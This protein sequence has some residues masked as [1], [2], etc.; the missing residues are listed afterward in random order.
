MGK[1]N[2][3]TYRVE[4]LVKHIAGDLDRINSLLSLFNISVSSLPTEYRYGNDEKLL[5]P[6]KKHLMKIA[7]YVGTIKTQFPKNKNKDRDILYYGTREEKA[8]KTKEAINLIEDHYSEIQPSSRNW[9]IFEGYTHPDLFIE[10]DDY[11]LIGEGKWTESHITTTTTNLS[12]DN[13][14][15]N[16]MIRHIQAALNYSNKKIYAFY[17]VDS[18]CCYLSD[19]AI[20]A[21]AK[22]LECETIKIDLDEKKKILD[23]YVGYV[24]WQDIEKQLEGLKFRTK[25]EID[26]AYK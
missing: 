11:I 24:T 2:S 8:K 14:Y 1:Y 6:T 19:L 21:F 25:E 26:K 18:E 7:E 3:S 13:E 23:C 16:Q 9:Y 15:R 5:K 22:Q 4:P 17:L 10:G 20:D 12:G